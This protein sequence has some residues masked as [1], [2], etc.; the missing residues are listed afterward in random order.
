MPSN[1]KVKKNNDIV[2]EIIGLKNAVSLAFMNTATVSVL[3]TDTAG[4]TVLT[5]QTLSY[6][7]ASDGDYRVTID[8]AAVSAVLTLGERYTAI[9]TSVDGGIDGSWEDD[10]AYVSRKTK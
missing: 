1:I 5:S 8:K 2:A 9:F 7:A 10:F 3:F 4:A 6:V